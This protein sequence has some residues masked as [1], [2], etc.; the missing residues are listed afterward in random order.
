MRD[1]ENL[2]RTK[3][4]LIVLEG[5]PVHK[6]LSEVDDAPNSLIIMAANSKDRISFL[7]PHTSFLVAVRTS[8]SVLILP[9]EDINE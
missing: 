7:N 6:I 9:D 5:N 8:N 4:P 3:I 2:T 1:Y